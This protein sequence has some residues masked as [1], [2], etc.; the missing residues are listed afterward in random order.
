MIGHTITEIT[1]QAISLGYTT[2][3]WMGQTY[4]IDEIRQ[5]LADDQL[6]TW[7]FYYRGMITHVDTRAVTSTERPS[8]ADVEA[9]NGGPGSSAT[10]NG[11]TWT[12]TPQILFPI[13]L[14]PNGDKQAAWD[15]IAAA[16]SAVGSLAD[17]DRASYERLCAEHGVTPMDDETC[18]GGRYSAGLDHSADPTGD[19][20]VSAILAAGRRA[21]VERESELGLEPEFPSVEILRPARSYTN[22]ADQVAS[23]L[24][25][26]A[27]TEATRRGVCH[28]CGLP[29][30]YGVCEEC[31]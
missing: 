16:R 24:G 11:T 8:K 4:T 21:I 10:L 25:F 12:I 28:Y 26:P 6:G 5:L 1:D 23:L 15:R 3:L 31:V 7:S 13:E 27:P 20:R 14:H 17:I 29:L 22:A 30:T 18:T 19:L 2:A 9:V